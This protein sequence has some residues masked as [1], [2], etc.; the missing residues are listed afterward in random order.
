VNPLFD[1]L[2]ILSGLLVGVASGV[3]GVGGGVFLVPIM[4]L[5]FGMPQHLAQGTSLAAILPTSAVGAWT[6]NRHGNLHRRA[7]LVIGLTG[8]VGAAIGATVALSLPRDLLAR[9]FGLVLLYAA[10]RIWPRGRQTD[11]GDDGAEPA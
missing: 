6:H 5:G 9:G 8:A 11:E 4:T 3:L 1:A 2:A 7:A 10:Y